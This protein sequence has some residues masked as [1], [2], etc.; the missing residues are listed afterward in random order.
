MLH[1]FKDK[2]LRMILRLALQRKPFAK[3]LLGL[4]QSISSA[5]KDFRVLPV[6]WLDGLT[7]EKNALL[8]SGTPSLSFSPHFIG[9]AQLSEKV[10]LPDVCYH[11]FTN[12]KISP[13]SSSVIVDDKKIV[14]E[15]AAVP[16]QNMHNYA[17]GHLRL[18]D[19]SHAVIHSFIEKKLGCGI[20][21]GGNGSWNYYHWMLELL[22]KLEFV[23]QLPER[24]QGFPLLVNE[25]ILATPSLRAS[26]YVFSSSLAIFPKIIGL[27]KEFSYAVGELVY[28]NSANGLPFNLAA[29]ARFKYTYSSLDGRSVAYLRSTALHSAARSLRPGNQGRRIFLSRK[30]G[31]RNFNQ[32][33]VFDFLEGYG[34]RKV[35][36]EDI[37]FLDQVQTM[38]QAEFIV[39][40]TGAAWTNLIFSRAGS[41]ALCW[42][43]EESC[44]F[45][46]YSNIAKIVGVDL[47]YITYRAG[48]DTTDDLY[49]K[50]YVVDIER[51]KSGLGEL[52][53]QVN[54]SATS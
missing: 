8:R 7:T 3:A 39:G 26:L 5:G 36:M 21:L 20:F 16:D 22:A 52:G 19:G 6:I 41:K 1:G 32:D 35:F 31:R 15:R 44:D 54:Q 23:R 34:F 29:G 38:N 40:P 33:E 45:S 51:I 9:R 24:F 49:T 11:I 48:V 12:S 17:G 43:A 13:V 42:M 10:N 18:H 46:A 25:D 30:K 2:C 37:G 4:Y 50:E 28:I 27:K 53:L 14:I 47:R